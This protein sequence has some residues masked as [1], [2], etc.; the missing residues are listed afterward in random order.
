[1]Y[2]LQQSLTHSLIHSLTLVILGPGKGIE[3]MY[4]TV[5]VTRLQTTL[6]TMQR[7]DLKLSAWLNHITVHIHGT[8]NST[9]PI[10]PPRLSFNLIS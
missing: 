8:E 7:V 4:C 1:M 6:T 5:R 9:A 10:H 2:L 3:T